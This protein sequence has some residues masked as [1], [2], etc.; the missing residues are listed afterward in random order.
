MLRAVTFALAQGTA[1]QI[2]PDPPWIP[3]IKLSLCSQSE[4]LFCRRGGPH[5]TRFPPAHVGRGL[6]HPS[7]P[8]KMLH[9]HVCQKPL[10]IHNGLPMHVKSRKENP[11]GCRKPAFLWVSAR[12]GSWSFL[13]ISSRQLFRRL[14]QRGLIADLKMADGSVKYLLDWSALIAEN[15]T[16]Q[17]TSV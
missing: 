8:L 13:C 9:E 17:I 3:L 14:H 11:A 5:P 12:A 7:S 4:E 16:L 2:A 6:L 15:N 1:I 10:S